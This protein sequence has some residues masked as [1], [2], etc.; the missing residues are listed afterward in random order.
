M[1]MRCNRIDIE[2][3]CAFNSAVYIQSWPNTLKNDNKMTVWRKFCGGV[4][5]VHFE[6]WARII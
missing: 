3:E 2:N 5:G 4:L 6:G 1:I